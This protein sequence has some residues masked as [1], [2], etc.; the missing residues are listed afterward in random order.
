MTD[1]LV[2]ITDL[3]GGGAEKNLILLSRSWIN[4]GLKVKV[5]LLYKEG[6]YLE[7]LNSAGIQIMSL[8][9]RMRKAI[10]PL[11]S[12]IDKEKPKIIWTNLYPLT[13]ITA[14]ALKLTQHKPKAYF[15]HHNNMS[16][17][18]SNRLLL[19]VSKIL[20]KRIYSGSKISAVSKGLEKEL[21]TEFAICGN[22]LIT[23]YNPIECRT[24]ENFDKPQ[25][26]GSYSGIKLLSVGSLK[27]QKNFRNLVECAGILRRKGYEFRLIIAGEGSL[28]NELQDQIINL[29]LERNV[30]LVGYQ[31]DVSH[32][33]RHS[34]FFV[35]SSLYEGF[36]NVIVEALAHGR[37]VVSTDCDFGPRE[38]LTS[39]TYGY[40]CEI[41][42]PE[43][44]AA[45]IERA[46]VNK[47]NTSY[48]EER[49]IKSREYNVESISEQ[50]LSW[51]G[52]NG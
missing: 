44:L 30:F 26:W 24:E 32:F 4:K 50:Y 12:V 16:R 39:E 21:R 13:A 14:I 31:E 41:N 15:T 29:N 38:I 6:I 35:L 18:I 27:S 5:L 23:I 45:S 9:V 46:I 17:S 36:G 48:S 40:L 2:F 7:E 51:F 52:I 42:N 33:Y 11:V 47:K 37:F 22:Q 43:S 1:I 28:R 8:E 25:L 3:N 49:I 20:L 19:P 10:R 34:D